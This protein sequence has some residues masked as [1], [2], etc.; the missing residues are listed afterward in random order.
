[1]LVSSSFASPE[2]PREVYRRKAKRRGRP[3]ENRTCEIGMSNGRCMSQNVVY[4]FF[5]P[6]VERSMWKRRND[7]SGGESSS[8]TE[9]PESVHP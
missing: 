5:V 4:S 8:I 1:M 6:F 3:V 9:K 7:L 2:C